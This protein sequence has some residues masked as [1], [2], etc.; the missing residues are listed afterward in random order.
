MHL[1]RIPNRQSLFNW[2][3]CNF[4]IQIEHYF[5]YVSIN[6]CM[7]TWKMDVWI[8]FDEANISTGQWN[9][10]KKRSSAVSLLKPSESDRLP[11][12]N[13]SLF[14]SILSFCSMENLFSVLMILSQHGFS[15]GNPV[16]A[17]RRPSEGSRE[18]FVQIYC[19]S[20]AGLLLNI[21]TETR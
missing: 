5:S 11:K 15:I 3:R 14:L 19:F 20:L 13:A 1:S 21:L 4:C 12:L 7:T 6:G 16:Q 17:V 18:L 2:S 8:F 10:W 9:L